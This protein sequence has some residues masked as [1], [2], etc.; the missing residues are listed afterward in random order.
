VATKLSFTQAGTGAVT[1]NVD[2]K[3]KDV[4]SVKD[5]GAVGD[6]V[7]DDTAAI[8]AA[9]NA[10]SAVSFPS[11]T[12]YCSDS[13]NIS[14]SKALSGDK[15][16]L[17]FASDKQLLVGGVELGTILPGAAIAA[18]DTTLP[19]GGAGQAND[20][21]WIEGN[22]SRSPAANITLSTTTLSAAVTVTASAS[23]FLATDVGK[24][25][26]AGGGSVF[27]NSYTS[28][29]QVS[30]FVSNNN[31]P[32]STTFN[33]GNFSI[34]TLFAQSRPYY[35]TGEICTSS[36]GNNI[37]A[38]CLEDYST[39]YVIHHIRPISVVI[40]GLTV[41]GNANAA[42]IRLQ[43]G[44]N[45]TLSNCVVE[46]AS[47]GA[48][49]WGIEVTKSANTLVDNCVID[50]GSYSSFTA[51][52]AQHVLVRG[53]YFR[54]VNHAIDA[55]SSS[56]TPP[57]RFLRATGCTLVSTG[58]TYAAYTHAGA[59]DVV[60]ENCTVIGGAAIF[61]KDSTISRCQVFQ[62]GGGPA[63]RLYPE[64]SG[65]YI[66]CI[67]NNIKSSGGNGIG[68]RDNYPRA[69]AVPVVDI[70]GNT[71]TSTNEGIFFTVRSE[72]LTAPHL[73]SN[74]V[75]QGN[76]ASSSAANGLIFNTASKNADSKISVQITSNNLSGSIRACGVLGGSSQD[77]R[78]VLLFANKMVCA[79]G[80]KGFELSNCL[81][82]DVYFNEVRGL[83]TGGT[84]NVVDGSLNAFNIKA[85]IIQN[86]TTD[87]GLVAANTFDRTL[88]SI[89]DNRFLSVAGTKASTVRMPFLRP[90]LDTIWSRSNVAPTGGTYQ[91]GDIVWNN[92][93]SASGFI[94]WV[95]VTAGAPGTWKTFGAISA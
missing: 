95:C 49:S 19:V 94:G 17:L 38:P 30:G 14:A 23:C 21:F 79:Q 59:S 84:N 22:D 20:I 33:S 8:Q 13:V 63:V 52:G 28:A 6:G 88:S 92:T 90:D 35:Y 86:F 70:L 29:T 16:T 80:G 43:H 40:N 46:N 72:F 81:Y 83:G 71:V 4:V 45:S 24:N 82:N 68:L 27:I 64:A 60:F 73:I 65:G 66:K 18:G 11:G 10:A 3:L 32:S 69:T 48:S 53:G 47:T 2:S 41:K 9:I 56:A 12:Y 44:I 54:C 62:Q 61:C 37:E 67:N 42:L 74:I 89:A 31:A 75:V 7:V 85:N 15:A 57:T 36:G 77:V 5:F 55:S 1:R 51:F 26:I 93:P 58:N 50:S 91:V 76:S 39:D 34:R 87:W 78:Y 25:I